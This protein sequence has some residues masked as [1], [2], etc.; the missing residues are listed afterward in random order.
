MTS[1]TIRADEDSYLL[2]ARA[3]ST[4][5]GGDTS[6]NELFRRVGYP[7][8]ISPVYAFTNDPAI[9]YRAVQVL[10]A[11]V[12]ATTF[13][14]A[15]SMGRR[16]FGWRQPLALLGAAA[17]ASMPAVAFYAGFALTDAVLAPVF[18]AWLLALHALLG[19][20]RSAAAA[21]LAGAA[22][23]LAYLIHVRGLVV[24]ALHASV[25]LLLAVRGK[26]LT[27]PIL[28]SAAAAACGVLLNSMLVTVLGDGMRLGGVSP[29]GSDV[30]HA[31][32]AAGLAATGLSATGQLWYL[33]VAGFGLTALGM[34][35]IPMWRHRDRTAMAVML[36]AALATVGIA[37][38]SAGVLQSVG[39][40]RM[41]Y[42][43]Y[44]RYVHVFGPFWMLAGIAA[45]TPPVRRHFGVL[46]GA[47]LL[48]VGGGALVAWRMRTGSMLPGFYPFDSPELSLLTDGW[49]TLRPLRATALGLGAIGT[50]AAVWLLRGRRRPAYIGVV[51]GLVIA[52][53]AVM[54]PATARLISVPMMNASLPQPPLADLGVRPGDTV[55]V[56]SGVVWWELRN[57]QREVNWSPVATFADR[58]S[59]G[60]RVVV[61]YYAPGTPAYWNGAKYGFHLVGTG[62]P[63]WAVWRIDPPR[64]PVPGT[65]RRPPIAGRLRSS[66]DP[67]RR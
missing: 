40:N 50:V 23:G 18:L 17:A 52:V 6:E 10:N 9:A 57:V 27:A 15:Y 63:Y 43:A 8:L 29:D 48:V 60:T 54:I 21:A 14:L 26:R 58:P 47:V 30:E 34:A 13:L 20:P 41:N 42:L 46:A 56:H 22:A 16:M 61:G 45:I 51:L 25:L 53:Q 5:V 35:A 59:A 39:A 55:A 62:K 4:G 12:N 44:A 3:L 11:V 7:L 67:V 24:I 32:T 36:V 33:A 2:T 64:L 66:A 37:L 49:T 1:P 19:R 65:K 28:F 31:T 38:L